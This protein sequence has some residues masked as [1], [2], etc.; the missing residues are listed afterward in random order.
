MRTAFLALILLMAPML[1]ATPG[2]STTGNK[3]L[4]SDLSRQDVVLLIGDAKAVAGDIR[5]TM[6]EQGKG[7]AVER[8]NQ[9]IQALNLVQDAIG[10]DDG[11]SVEEAADFLR[12]AYD[13]AKPHVPEKYESEVQLLATVIDRVMV[14]LEMM[15]GTPSTQPSFYFDSQLLNSD[16]L[17]AKHGNK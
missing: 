8:T 17:L 6:K 3:N 16:H 13:V 14:R 11:V 10:D 2:C 9:V 12:F 15:Q 5:A 1:V 4:L 7:K